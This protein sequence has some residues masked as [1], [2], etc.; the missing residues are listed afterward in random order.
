M[1]LPP[2]RRSWPVLSLL[3]WSLVLALGIATF[4]RP[5]DSGPT[6]VAPPGHRAGSP[7]DVARPR[8]LSHAVP[9]A[10]PL[11]PAHTKA[12]ASTL[13]LVAAPAFGS[14]SRA[15]T[16]TSRISPGATEAYTAPRGRSGCRGPPGAVMMS[17]TDDR[18][19]LA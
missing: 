11:A 1:L 8:P 18:E 14:I 3:V 2:G 6:I 7:A 10:L 12:T 19:A 5:P 15:T 13:E 17:Q 4:G 16:W 9:A